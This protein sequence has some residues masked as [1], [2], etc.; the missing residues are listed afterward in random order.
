M[1]A[2]RLDASWS[3]QEEAS[4][5]LPAIACL[6]AAARNMELIL[7]WFSN[8]GQQKIQTTSLQL[9]QLLSSGVFA[10]KLPAQAH[11]EAVV[12]CTYTL[13]GASHN[14]EQHM[15]NDSLQEF[16]SKLYLNWHQ[17]LNP[18]AFDE[19]IHVFLTCYK[20]TSVVPMQ[21]SI[22]PLIGIL[23]SIMYGAS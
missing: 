6:E 20:V 7:N 18:E 14:S 16:V 17:E 10:V 3:G 9:D 13:A 21:A 22:A 1:R 5:A 12:S 15:S 19:S 11:K 2:L 4:T 23:A 8:N